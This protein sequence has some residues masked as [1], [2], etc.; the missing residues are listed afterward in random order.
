[1]QFVPNWFVTRDWV[2]MW[3]DDYYED[4]SGHWD[5]DDDDD[6]KCFEWYDEYKKLKAQ[7]ASVKEEPLPIAWHS[8]K[9]W[10]W[11]MSE[12]ET[13]KLRG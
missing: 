1:M 2:Y 6:D 9:Y 10:D 4:D 13:E 3:Y 11:C 8:S 7:K 5:D 12:D